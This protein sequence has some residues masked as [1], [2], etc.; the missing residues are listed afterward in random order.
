MGEYESQE[1]IKD[2]EESFGRTGSQWFFIEKK[3][4]QKIGWTAKYLIGNLTTI[5]FGI[6]PDERCKGCATEAV[7]LIVDYLFLTN[8]IVRVQADTGTEN[9]ASQRVLEKAGFEKEG[10]IRSHYFCTGRWRDSF[11]Y[12]I[13]RE[14][15]KEPK[16]LTKTA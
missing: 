12:S 16:I 1:S 15:W 2:L 11:L 14:E 5:G 6:I 10:I 3:D 13:L 7:D 8:N 9:K 4:R